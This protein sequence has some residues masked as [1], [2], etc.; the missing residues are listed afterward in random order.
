METDV[1]DA[2]PES[3]ADAPNVQAGQ[4]AARVYKRARRLRTL[5][6]FST[7]AIAGLRAF[8]PTLF[9]SILGGALSTPPAF[10]IYLFASAS[11]VCLEWM[12]R[13]RYLESIA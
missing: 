1:F 3:C 7:L 5:V 2:H 10:G 8:A 4:I 11:T 9:A 6:V 13:E 12:T